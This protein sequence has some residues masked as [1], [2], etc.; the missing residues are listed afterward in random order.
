MRDEAPTLRVRV[1]RHGSVVHE[2]LCESTEQADRVMAEWS[3]E[4]D[5]RIEVVDLVATTERVDADDREVSS[6]ADEW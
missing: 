4:A 2:E 5:V 1:L 3:D 6:D